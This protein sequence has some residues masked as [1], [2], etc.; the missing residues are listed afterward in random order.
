MFFE[1]PLTEKLHECKRKKIKLIFPIL[2]ILSNNNQAYLS[3]WKYLNDMPERFYNEGACEDI[4]NFL[5][6][7]KDKEPS[8]LVKILK[9]NEFQ[10]MGFKSLNEINSLKFHDIAIPSNKYDLMRFCDNSIHPNYLKLVEGVYSNLIFPIGF[11]QRIKRGVGLEGF[12]IYSRVEELKG[13]YEYLSNPYN[14]TIR[15]AIAH[16]KVV[17][18]P[19]DITYKD[20]KNEITLSY[21]DTINLFDN[22][23]D[24][25]NGLSL[26]FCLFYFANLEF[27]EKNDIIIPLPIMMEELKAETNGTGWKIRGH[28]ESEIFGN[29]SQLTIFA[30]NDFF[31]RIKL[32]YHV[33]CSAIFAEK[34]SPGYQRYFVSLDSKYSLSGWAAFD[35]SELCKLRNVNSNNI[36]DYFKTLEGGLISFLP[37]FKLPNF[38]FKVA[39]FFS[40]I[41]INL[42]VTLLEFKE[43][44]YNLSL[45]PRKVSIHQNKFHSVVN[46]SVIVV[47]NSNSPI[48]ELIR[49]NSG[50]IVRKTIKKARKNA[51]ITDISKY[52]PVGYLR[53]SIYSKD[54]RVRKLENSG[55]IPEL[56]CTIEFKRLQRIQTID[57]IG[58]IPE[59]VNKLRIVWNENAKIIE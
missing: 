32:N 40:I 44:F 25:S 37:K 17:F 4:L 38:I 51:K 19:N 5:N 21:R 47:P 26:G 1:S 50:S 20:D 18:K 56:L 16:D 3:I 54:F 43:K 30:K 33:F 14:H 31:D 58:G 6:D 13:T 46:G 59:K 27:L 8:T 39:T 7:I 23:L 10:S 49:N 42:P 15:N 48:D 34:L 9:E 22:M 35:G 28:L 29:R 12:K 24:I 11:Y 2:S 57:I 36:E 41:W 55:L 53:I 45:K 52:L